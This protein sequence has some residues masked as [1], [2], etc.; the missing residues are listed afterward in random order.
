MISAI[1]RLTGLE[2]YIELGGMNAFRMQVRFRPPGAPTDRGH[3]GHFENESLRDRSQTMRFGERNAG[4]EPHPHEHRSFI[5][6]RQ[7]GARKHSGSRSGSN[8]AHQSQG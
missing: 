5:E 8:D 4:L 6:G 3:I 1:G 7:E 2:I